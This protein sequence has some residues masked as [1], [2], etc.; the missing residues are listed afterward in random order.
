MAV[1][2]LNEIY[3]LSYTALRR[4][5]ASELQAKPTAVSIRDAEAEGIRNVGLGYLPVYLAHLRCGK[6]KGDVVPK[7]VNDTGAVIHVDAQLGFC[8]AAFMHAFEPFAARAKEMGVGV[9]SISNSY[10]AGVVGWFNDLLAQEGLV[11]LAFANSSPAVAPFGGKRPF[12]GTNPLGFG[13]P[14]ANHDPIIVDMATSGTAYV[15]ILRAAADGNQIPLGWAVD[16]NGQPTT[17]PNA[18]LA[19]ALAPLGGAKGFGL[20]MM[21]D[22][23]AAGLTGSHWSHQS[24]D[25]INNEGGPP[26]VGQLFIAL[27]PASMGGD[28]Y[29]ERIE[30]WAEALL[31]QEGVRLPG[32]KRYAA[33][34]AAE[35]NGVEV[36]EELIEQIQS[37]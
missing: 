16:S 20:G 34:V 22:I 30:S 33:R 14:R 9:L 35:A 3:E 19:G 5:G 4:C 29:L 27:D 28:A 10:S 31:G 13:A 11:N 24:A 36:P 12:F 8:H 21:V 7:I 2:T 32:S 1:L 18:G 25:F 37:T 15:N 23:L 6:V 17:D 26:S